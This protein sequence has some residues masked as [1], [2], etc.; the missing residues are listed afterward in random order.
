M[1]V[2][3]NKGLSIG[4]LSMTPMI[5]VVFLLLIFFLVASRFEEEERSMDVNLPQVAETE[6]TA[7][8]GREVFVTVTPAGE[9]YMDGHRM[10]TTVLR[11]QLKSLYAANPGKQRVTIRADQKSQS[12]A[13]VAVLDACNQANIRNYSIATE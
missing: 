3:L 2:K 5:D 9:Y 13:L 1:S 7:F 8:P 12:G 6:P 11:A 4:A 10:S